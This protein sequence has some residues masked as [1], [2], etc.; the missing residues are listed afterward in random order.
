MKLHKDFYYL[1]SWAIIFILLSSLVFLALLNNRYILLSSDVVFD[2]WSR[3]YLKPIHRENPKPEKITNA[4]IDLNKFPD[5][6]P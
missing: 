3:Q 2:K 6:Q 1:I 4:P 5:N